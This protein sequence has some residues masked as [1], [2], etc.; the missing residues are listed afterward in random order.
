MRIGITYD[1][2]RKP[3]SNLPEDIFEELDSIETVEAV[4]SVLKHAGHEV[5]RLGGGRDFLLSILNT[6]VDLVFNLAEGWGT[7]SREAHVPSVLELLGIPYTGSDPLTLA[8]TLDKGMAKKVV[9][10][11]GVLTPKFIVLHNPIALNHDIE[12]NYPLILKPLWE[13]SSIGIRRDSKVDNFQELKK[14]LEWLHNSYGEPTLVEEFIEGEEITVG[15]TG[16]ENPQIIGM[17]MIRPVNGDRRDFIYSLEV[18]RN[19]REEVEYISPP[20]LSDETLDELSHSALLAYEA[21]TCRDIARLDFRIGVDGK[22]YFLEA[23]P[24]PGLN[25]ETGDLPIMIEKEGLPY[26]E[27]ILSI[28]DNAL[29]RNRLTAKSRARV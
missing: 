16:N 28:L 4:E 15:V 12:L 23:N 24:L 9:E 26:A 20:Q 10:N 11:A 3:T 2:K 19:W 29:R 7:R 22:P 13:G 27:L 6:Q 1:L 8:L 5:V 25:P 21:L 14:K 18:K 17:M